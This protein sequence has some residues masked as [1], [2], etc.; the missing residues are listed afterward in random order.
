MSVNREREREAEGELV[1]DW[2]NQ[3]VFFV[4]SPLVF[5]LFRLRGLFLLKIYNYEALQWLLMLYQRPSSHRL[6]QSFPNRCTRHLMSFEKRSL[7]IWS[8]FL[9]QPAV[10]I[11]VF[12]YVHLRSIARPVSL[13]QRSTSDFHYDSPMSVRLCATFLSGDVLFW[14]YLW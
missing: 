11:V 1:I 14:S 7:F 10:I 9:G 6:S 4:F 12:Y 8:L 3:R 2:K 5:L 13:R